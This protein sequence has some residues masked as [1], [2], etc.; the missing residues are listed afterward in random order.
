MPSRGSQVQAIVREVEVVVMDL[1]GDHSQYTIRFA[2]D[3]AQPL[4]AEFQTALV[5]QSLDLV[6]IPRNSVG[7][8][9]LPDLS[10]AE[11]TQTSSTSV[12]IDTGTAPSNGGGFEVR[13]SDSGWGAAIDRNL[14]GRFNMR[15]FT[16]PR[17]A[18][19]QNYY[20][21]QYDNSSPV[22]YSRYSAALHLDFPL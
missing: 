17:L 2:N 14:V 22:K 4:A 12:T 3:A 20:L 16:V 18:R 11:I 10:A 1:A 5:K 15:T 7:A 9:I 21:R 19:V 6:A 8:T 13:W